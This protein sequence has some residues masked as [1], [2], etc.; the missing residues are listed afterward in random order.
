ML[1]TKIFK[2]IHLKQVVMSAA[3][4]GGLELFDFVIYLFLSPFIATQ[5][6]PHKNDGIA[7]LAT[8]GGFAAGY[9]AR[10]LGGI[11]YGHFGDRIGR[12]RTLASSLFLMAIPTFFISCL[13]TYSTLG[14]IA[15]LLLILFRFA[16][17]L[18]M[19]GD[20]PGAICFIGEHVAMKNRGFMT[21]C[22]MFGMNMGAVIAS[23]LVAG[24]IS[25]LTPLA[26]LNWGWR[27]PFFIGALLAVVGFYI[28]QR[29]SETPEFRKY[30]ELG[31]LE[32]WPLK[33]LLRNHRRSIGLGF[34]VAALAAAITAVMSLFMGTYLSHYV[35]IKPNIALWLNSISICAYSLSCLGIGF[36]IDRFSALT[37][38]RVGAITLFL[39]VYPI[40]MLI[41]THQLLF[42]LLALLISAP[43]LASIMTPI[44]SILIELFPT[45]IRYSGIGISYNVG[46]SLFAGTSPL[47][48]TLFIS[49][50]GIKLIPAF[51]IM[52]IIGLAF[53][54]VS[55]L[56]NT[57]LS[58]SIKK[59]ET[60][61]S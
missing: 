39:L 31:K 33:T 55:F 17:G 34:C 19:G 8:L 9:F 6:F 10:P 20:I 50:T 46:F 25:L 60:Q 18:A 51:Y 59:T 48:V 4:G 28:R 3:I 27:I 7:L 35:G 1:S 44:P 53:P 26:M 41:S 29:T 54:T 23:V 36:A 43:L 12:I 2:S 30:L 52:F 45:R 21:S 57:E 24:I 5:F 40:F 61:A 14:I 58:I 42:I 38:L 15:P 47:L 16:Q 13:P 56:R 37:V 49:M 32:R 22:L 11:I